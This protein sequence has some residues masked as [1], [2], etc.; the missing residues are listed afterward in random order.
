M[1]S[2]PLSPGTKRREAVIQVSLVAAK[3]HT[4]PV[5]GHAHVV[6]EGKWQRLFQKE[7]LDDKEV[8]V[9]FQAE[10]YVERYVAIVCD[11]CNTRTQIEPDH[12]V[13]LLADNLQLQMLLAAKNGMT[14]IPCF[15][16]KV[17]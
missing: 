4:C 13:K 3:P 8:G 12:V 17:N 1:S 10:D 11:N 2:K 5:C 7:F 14:A 15:E 6:L 16:G 9:V